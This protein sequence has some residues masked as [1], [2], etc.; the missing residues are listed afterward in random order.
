MI[1]NKVQIQFIIEYDNTVSGQK[2]F[3]HPL[4]IP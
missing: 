3:E 1:E 4:K 2:F